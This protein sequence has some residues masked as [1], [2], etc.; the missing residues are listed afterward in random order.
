MD[1][2]ERERYVLEEQI[3]R[4]KAKNAENRV[5]DVGLVK[6]EGEKV[7]LSFNLAGPSTTSTEAGPSNSVANTEEDVK[8]VI[9]FGTIST[10]LASTSSNPATT[11]V[12]ATNPLKR[13]APVNVF[14]QSKAPKTEMSDTASSLGGGK[15]G[16]MSESERLMKEDQARRMNGGP[17]GGAGR[18][19]YGGFGP[20]REGDGGRRFVLQ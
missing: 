19:G 4:A 6:Q 1:G 16:Y 17:R 18:G 20:K 11:A 10:P 9:S 14:K 13:P 7:V 3:A 15:K 5:E 12:I 8:P 2:E